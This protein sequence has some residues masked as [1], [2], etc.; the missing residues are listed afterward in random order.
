M[1]P[2]S[3]AHMY[4]HAQK[5]QSFVGSVCG[6]TGLPVIDVEL[7]RVGSGTYFCVLA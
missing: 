6:A 4:A 1:T 7:L 5:H 2:V 3:D